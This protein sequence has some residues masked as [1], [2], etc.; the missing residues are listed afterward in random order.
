MTGSLDGKRLLLGE[1]KW[2]PRPV[3]PR[4][5]ER[6]AAELRAR[7]EP[8][9]RGLS[10][11]PEVVRVLFFPALGDEARALLSKEPQLTVVTAQ[12][13]LALQDPARQ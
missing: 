4:E 2:S 8:P 11:E 12:D 1:A 6:A 7:K 10:G 13:L 3:S 5:L 9:V